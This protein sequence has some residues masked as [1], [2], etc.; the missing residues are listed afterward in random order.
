MNLP[1]LHAPR[2]A[3]CKV[4]KEATGCRGLCK[5]CFRD[6]TIRELYPCKKYHRAKPPGPPDLSLLDPAPPAFCRH[7]K[8]DGLCPT[9]EREQR[10]AMAIQCEEEGDERPLARR[11]R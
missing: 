9:C 4:N 5:R 1:D 8:K 11:S 2:C 6:L 10:M 7:G 3:H